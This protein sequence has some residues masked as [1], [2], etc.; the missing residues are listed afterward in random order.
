MPISE[1]KQKSRS[2]LW[3][4]SFAALSAG[5]IE[6]SRLE[7]LPFT[8][9]GYQKDVIDEFDQIFLQ[10]API[11]WVGAI[12][13]AL[14]SDNRFFRRPAF[15]S[16]LAASLVF[17]ALL[18]IAS[19]LFIPGN[20]ASSHFP[21][22]LY[23]AV[24]GSIEIL[25]FS[26][27][28]F[29]GRSSSERLQIFLTVQM[30]FSL[31][32]VASNSFTLATV[33]PHLNPYLLIM[34]LGV[35]SI[36]CAI[37]SIFLGRSTPHQTN[38]PDGIRQVWFSSNSKKKFGATLGLVF[39]FSCSA[40]VSTLFLPKTIQEGSNLVVYSMLAVTL[41]LPVALLL[42]RKARR[43]QLTAQ[44]VLVASSIFAVLLYTAKLFAAIFG[45]RAV[46]LAC[47]A[48]GSVFFIFVGAALL[49]KLSD[50]VHQQQA[51]NEK[52]RIAP[53]V[54]VYTIA[55]MLGNAG[56]LILKRIPFVF[57]D[58]FTIVAATLSIATWGILLGV[59]IL[60]G[61]DTNH[62]TKKHSPT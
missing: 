10:T 51:A 22:S 4:I 50:L 11:G 42:I 59:S 61:E 1:S 55:I 31:G 27:A 39:L 9:G 12:L 57:E 43:T 24:H 40:S 62:S 7:Y 16:A 34:A 20:P 53:T 35:V 5:L 26:S 41:A 6:P 45:F 33:G 52:T 58:N 60:V 2:T 21:L 56:G 54:L 8:A 13:A 30:M 17:S 25:L 48:A 46:E 19:S 49:S 18:F 28:V 29:I 47:T 37:P 3:I 38:A 32:N 15:I 14:F 23:F 36:C 44:R